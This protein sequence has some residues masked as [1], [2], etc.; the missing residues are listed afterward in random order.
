M[1]TSVSTNLSMVFWYRVSRAAQIYVLESSHGSNFNSGYRTI[2][3]KIY[4]I[5]SEAHWNR[6]WV[7]SPSLVLKEVEAHICI[8]IT[9]VL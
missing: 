9:Y 2:R 8:I 4:R 1:I 7:V 5:S 6:K 3:K